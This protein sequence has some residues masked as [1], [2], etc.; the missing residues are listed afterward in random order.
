M[1][2]FASRV[3][4]TID[5][6]HDPPQTVTIRK[7]TGRQYER[8]R[9]KAVFASMDSFRQ[10]GGKEMLRELDGLNMSTEA[11]A[12][13]KVKAD[14]LDSLDWDEL[15]KAGVVAWSYDAPVDEAHLLDL[16]ADTREWLARE[17]FALSKRR[18]EAE[19]KNG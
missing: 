10:A 5:V 1:S 15:L 11:V 13:A 12:A 18:Q 3:Q 17:I 9:E 19:T 14:A 7:I 2:I 16:D 4:K 6:P 8:A